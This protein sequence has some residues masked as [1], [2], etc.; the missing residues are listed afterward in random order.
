MALTISEEKPKITKFLTHNNI[1]V[2]ATSDS[3]GQPHAATIYFVVDP[4]LNVYFMTKERTTKFRNLQQNPK[5]ALA[6]YEAVSQSTVQIVGSAEL[7]EDTSRINDIFRR[8]L[9]VTAETSESHIPPVSKIVA[10]EHKCFCIKPKTLRLAEYTK[11]EHGKFDDLFDIAV[12]PD[13][14]L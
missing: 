13:G 11:P 6:I 2:L 4:N 12:V 8:V 1:G 10:G 3:S 7:V 9:A 14:Q 5:A